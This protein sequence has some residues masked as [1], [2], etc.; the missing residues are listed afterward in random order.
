M[1]MHMT[2]AL[3]NAS[4]F[5]LLTDTEVDAVSGGLFFLALGFAAG[6]VVGV[7]IGVAIALW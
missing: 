5:R 6:F 2:P 7:A 3:D 1:S 4:D